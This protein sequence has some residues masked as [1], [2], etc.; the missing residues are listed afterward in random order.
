MDLI[1]LKRKVD[2]VSANLRVREKEKQK[3]LKRLQEKYDIETLEDARKL[4]DKLKKQLI[5]IRKKREH[6]LNK[7]E[8][9]M[10]IYNELS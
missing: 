3:A 4:V 6:Y 1:A 2:D 7:I 10:E 5:Q 9:K 8:Q